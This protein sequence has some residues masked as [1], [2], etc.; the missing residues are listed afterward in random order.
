MNKQIASPQK[1]KLLRYLKKKFED[2]INFFIKLIFQI[3][4]GNNSKFGVIISEAFYQPWN[5]DKYFKYFYKS[6]LGLT[7]LDK[8]RLYI[9]Y[10]VVK[11]IKK[12]KGDIIEVGTWRGGS[13][14][15][16]ALTLR[17]ERIR[18]TIYT[19]DTFSGVIK[20]TK[21]DTYYKGTEHKN[22]DQIKL[23]KILKKKKLKI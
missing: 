15:M 7:M 10:Q 23:L 19:F 13:A 2:L 12:I 18:K 16:M 21:L 4:A 14:I 6:I 8:S 22:A 3:K 11:N 5:E 9:L 17:K 1:I 20:S